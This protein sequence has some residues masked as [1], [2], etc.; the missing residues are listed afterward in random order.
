MRA[1]AVVC[2]FTL[3]VLAQEQKPLPAEGAAT[4]AV[5]LGEGQHAYQWVRG[6]GRAERK[7]RPSPMYL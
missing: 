4:S 2:S 5:V 6:W 1:L 3:S 7:T